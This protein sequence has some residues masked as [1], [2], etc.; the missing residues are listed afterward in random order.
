M[1]QLIRCPH[2]GKPALSIASVKDVSEHHAQIR[3]T[4][5]R[6][7]VF[8]VRIDE[9][10]FSNRVRGDLENFQIY[11]RK[12]LNDWNSYHYRL[13]PIRTLGDLCLKTERDLHGPGN[14][15]GKVSI[16]EIKA[17]LKAHGLYLGM[18]DDDLATPVR[19]S[20]SNEEASDVV[21]AN[22]TFL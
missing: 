15:L 18:T 21:N 8:S 1:T 5:D 16:A 17:V 13:A 22:P 14:R 12:D 9:A 7:K 4:R 20:V 2:C 10:G 6:V 19:E 11:E 3:K